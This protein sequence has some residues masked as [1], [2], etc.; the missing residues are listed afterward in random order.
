MSQFYFTGRLCQL[1]FLI[2]LSKF[3]KIT[4]RHEGLDFS[5]YLAPDKVL[6]FNKF[7]GNKYQEQT[8]QENPKL[9]REKTPISTPTINNSQEAH[10]NH[11]NRSIKIKDDQM[12]RLDC[13]PTFFDSMNIEENLNNNIGLENIKDLDTISES[14]IPAP[15][16][17]EIF[18]ELPDS[19]FEGD[20]MG[21]QEPPSSSCQL[22]SPPVEEAV[23]IKSEKSGFDLIKYIIFG[24]VNELQTFNGS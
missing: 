23:E 19:L 9:S 8:I 21:K 1:Q 11:L 6:T 12:F 14:W 16:D 18:S 3:L 15:A 24:E 10:G 13:D 4:E 22:P 17:I 5:E 7:T 2:F 20:M